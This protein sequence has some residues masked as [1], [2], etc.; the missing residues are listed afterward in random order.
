MYK[1]IRE[2]KSISSIKIFENDNCT[3]ESR[4]MI[5]LPKGSIWQ[6]VKNNKDRIKIKSY[7]KL[8][9]CDD[10]II[11]SRHVEYNKFSDC[12]YNAIYVI[13]P[14]SN[15]II[16]DPYISKKKIFNLN[17]FREVNSP[18]GNGAF[19]MKTYESFV[20]AKLMYLIET[21]PNY[22]I[23]IDYHLLTWDLFEG[24]DRKYDIHGIY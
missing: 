3:I 21:Y 2:H 6:F 7:K 14:W 20:I 18:H 5:I 11:L 16:I 17:V 9:Y 8:Y 4:T 13:G 12:Y 10:N 19:Y 1:D 24:E 15:N 23:W 22:N